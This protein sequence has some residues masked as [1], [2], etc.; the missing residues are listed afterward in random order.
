MRRFNA[1]E[2]QRKCVRLSH[3]EQLGFLGVNP[4]RPLDQ[5]L[6]GPRA[7]LVLLFLSIF[8]LFELL[9]SRSGLKSRYP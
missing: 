3:H 1:F 4:N 9:D 7:P 8:D 6:H 2:W 5:G